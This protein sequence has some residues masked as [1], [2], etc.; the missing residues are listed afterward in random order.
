MEERIVP[1]RRSATA[2]SQEHPAPRG[3]TVK[4]RI[5]RGDRYSAPEVYRLE[6]T[7]LE[8]VRGKEAWARVK[9]QGVAGE[10]RAG[11]EYVLCR[12]RFGYFSGAREFPHSGEAY[13]ISPEHFVAVAAD[14]K[15]EFEG[16]S[17]SRQP[18]PALIGTAFSVNESREGWILLQ[19]PE[20]GREVLLAFR[21]EYAEN[22][23]GVWGPVWFQLQ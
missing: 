3:T 19:L 21:R 1:E 14:G 11:F 4:T 5:E 2:G 10:V 18:Q 9:E 8:I 6:I 13:T 7:L 20:D 16:P 23:Y 22:R 15:T 12:I 17:V